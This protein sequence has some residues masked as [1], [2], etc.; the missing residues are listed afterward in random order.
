MSLRTVTLI[1]AVACSASFASADSKK[2]AKPRHVDPPQSVGQIA[3]T[4]YGCVPIPPNCHP[5]TD[6]YWNGMPTGYDRIICR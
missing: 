1:C 4:K 6:Y 5:D 2:P 3:C